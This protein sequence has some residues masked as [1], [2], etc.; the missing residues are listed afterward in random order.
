VRKVQKNPQPEK[1]RAKESAYLL[2]PWACKHYPDYS[3][4]EAYIPG[5]DWETIAEV[6][7]NPGV[8]AELIAG[9]IT[10]TVNNHEKNRD[11]FM[12]TAYALELC[13]SCD[14]KLSWEAEQEAQVLLVRI[15][16]AAGGMI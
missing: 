5:R 6:I 16:E 11:L 14:A 10:R 1:P 13:L 3:E 12:Q 4:I 9:F 2:L 15:K 8:N 7:A